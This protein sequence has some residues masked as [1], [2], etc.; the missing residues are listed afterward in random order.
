MKSIACRR[1][2]NPRVVA[3]DYL[4]IL[5]MAG[6]FLGHGLLP[7]V[8][9]FA[10]RYST[11]T[12]GVVT[13][14]VISGYVILRVLLYDMESGE[15]L[16]K[17]YVRRFCRIVPAYWVICA[18]ATLLPWTIRV[19]PTVVPAVGHAIAALPGMDHFTALHGIRDAARTAHLDMDYSFGLRNPED[20]E[21]R[22]CAW[23]YY[24]NQWYV[25]NPTRR[26]HSNRPDGHCW[27]LCVEEQ[28]YLVAPIVILI[29]MKLGGR[30]LLWKVICFGA[31]PLSV[32][33]VIYYELWPHPEG[34]VHIATLPNVLP[35]SLA[36]WQRY[37]KE[38]SAPSYAFGRLRV[39]AL[40]IHGSDDDRRIAFRWPIPS[41]P[42]LVRRRHRLCGDLRRRA[43]AACT[44]LSF[45]RKLDGILRPIDL[46]HV[47]LARRGDLLGGPVPSRGLGIVRGRVYFNHLAVAAFLQAR[48]VPDDALGPQNRRQ[49]PRPP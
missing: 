21:P 40:W 7:P 38:K 11:A 49:P 6:V 33:S 14:F 37:W 23:L 30:E 22:L 34:A 32:A 4:R 44:R 28:F 27:S 47:P 48:R 26:G 46:W 39:P 19:T 8:Q 36:H 3:I 43:L 31:I 9:Q 17:F 1:R 35:I 25:W 42:G 2:S 5:C 12:M 45:A 41:L 24:G 16:W 29:A 10:M 15:P 13:F 20:Y 18:T